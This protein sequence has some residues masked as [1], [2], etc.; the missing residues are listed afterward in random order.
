MLDSLPTPEKPWNRR[1]AILVKPVG[2]VGGGG[3]Y[4]VGG[5]AV[6]VTGN[7][8]SGDS[9][10]DPHSKVEKVKKKK[11]VKHKMI[12]I[13]G[14]PREGELAYKIHPDHWGKGYMA[15]TMRMFLGM[16]WESEGL[17]VFF[18][19]LVFIFR[20]LQFLLSRKD[21]RFYQKI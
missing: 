7:G 15:E 21:L 6:T 17:F 20:H 4:V 8:S 19:F 5:E 11:G 2:V 1:W 9:N 14:M 12:G 10:S 18:S 16:L 13:V 3:E